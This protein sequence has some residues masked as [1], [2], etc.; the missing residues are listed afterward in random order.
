M[1]VGVPGRLEAAV[2]ARL[3]R[4]N[5]GRN[6]PA[7]R[8]ATSAAA[9]LTCDGDVVVWDGRLILTKKNYKTGDCQRR[10]LQGRSPSALGGGG[11]SVVVS[12][13][14]ACAVGVPV[15]RWLMGVEAKPIK[16]TEP[17]LLL[18]ICCPSRRRDSATILV[19]V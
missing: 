3:A 14:L 8:D 5:P 15:R 19:Q 2:S 4:C 7:G 17:R 6:T 18:A 11:V 13:K 12:D 10:K 16:Y 1:G 9:M